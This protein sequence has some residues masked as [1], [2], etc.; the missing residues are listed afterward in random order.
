MKIKKTD[1]D[2]IREALDLGATLELGDRRFRSS[3][4]ITDQ[5]EAGETRD[6]VKN[7]KTG[8]YQEKWVRTQVVR[9]TH[10][11]AHGNGYV[12]LPAQAVARLA[13]KARALLEDPEALREADENARARLAGRA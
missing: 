7:R 9:T 5:I 1:L 11:K 8:R 13:E 2:T 12:W 6:L 3:R 10:I 4:E